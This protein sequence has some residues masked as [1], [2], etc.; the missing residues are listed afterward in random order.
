MIEL[1]HREVEVALG[2][3]IILTV[4]SISG[5]ADAYFSHLEMLHSWV[6]SIFNASL[7]ALTLSS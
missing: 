2:D 4:F 7:L 6:K 1:L 5:F 3:T